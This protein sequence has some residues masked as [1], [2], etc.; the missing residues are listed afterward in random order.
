VYAYETAKKCSKT[1]FATDGQ[2]KQLKVRKSKLR[3]RVKDYPT[4][5][6]I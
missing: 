5:P 6:Q 3:Q 4:K 2:L 1:A